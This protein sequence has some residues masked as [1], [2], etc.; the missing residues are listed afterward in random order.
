VY[1]RFAPN[2]RT[3]TLLDG[4][5]RVTRTLAAGAGLVAATRHGEDA[6]TWLVT[7][8]DATGV[9]RAARAFDEADLRDRFALALAPSGP[10]LAAP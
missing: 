7:G 9:G 3:L 5:G 8:T 6:P 2:G 1:A 10:P 4:A